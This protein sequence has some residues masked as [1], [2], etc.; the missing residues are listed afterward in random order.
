[1]E[2]AVND[3]IQQC[4]D[5]IIEAGLADA[6]TLLPDT[7]S[8]E[9]KAIPRSPFLEGQDKVLAE[10]E[11]ELL[12]F[13]MLAQPHHACDDET[14]IAILL[15]FGSLVDINHVF[16]SQTMEAKEFTESAYGFSIP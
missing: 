15:D 3:R 14:V 4:I 5:Q 6:A 12:S 9:I 10:K 8:Y 13:Q 1:R 2:V 11:T 16:Q 7:F